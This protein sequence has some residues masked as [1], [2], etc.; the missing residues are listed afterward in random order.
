MYKET[1]RLRTGFLAALMFVC[2]YAKAET[3]KRGFTD[4]KNRPSLFSNSS[5]T[6][7]IKRLSD[8]IYNLIG[9]NNYGLDREVF[10][11]A[12][13]GYRYLLNQNALRKKNLLTICDYSQSSRRKRLYVIDVIN[14]RLLF[15]TYVSHGT[16]S[17]AE[18]ATSFSNLPSSNK[19]SLGFLVTAETYAGIAGYSMRLNGME[20]GINDLVRSRDIVLH[21]SRFVNEAI[22]NVRGRIGNSYGCPAVPLGIHERIIDAIK[23]GSC[24]YIYNSDTWYKHT[25]Q[26]LNAKFDLDPSAAT[27]ENTSVPAPAIEP[28]ENSTVSSSVTNVQN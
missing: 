10:F 9:L 13:K 27:A 12:Y 3:G 19:S 8:S 26:I 1:L 20:A 4:D 6:P 16:N 11:N 21:G 17:G 24:F 14:S 18:Y 25:S 28:V 15:N 7:V 23:E 5:N 22:M 2:A